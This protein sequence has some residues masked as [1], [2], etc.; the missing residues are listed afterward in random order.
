MIVPRHIRHFFAALAGLCLAAGA[1]W[2]CLHHGRRGFLP[3]DQSI[4]FDGGWRVFRGQIPFVDFV[5]P[6]AIVPSVMQAAIFRVAGVTS[7]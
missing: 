1:A 2:L 5:T 7:T 6:A 4:V 3:L